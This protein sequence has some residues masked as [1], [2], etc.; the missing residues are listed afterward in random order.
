MAQLNIIDAE[1]QLRARGVSPFAAHA[2]IWL[3]ACGY[4]GLKTLDEAL[5]EGPK[6]FHLPR[7]ASGIDVQNSSCVFVGEQI[8]LYTLAHGRTSLRNV[9]HGLFLVPSSVALNISIGCAVDASFALGGPRIRNPYTEK[10][11][12]AEEAGIHVDDQ[13]WSRF[14]AR[15][16]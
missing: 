16:L 14:M 6:E 5:T 1:A 15:D 11:A 10:L 7:D 12:M 8:L 9:R 3:E 2:A 13:L 4:P